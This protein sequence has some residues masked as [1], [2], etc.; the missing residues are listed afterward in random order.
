MVDKSLVRSGATT[1]EVYNHK[2]A[3]PSNLEE[4]VKWATDNFRRIQ[5]MGYDIEQVIA[6]V[7]ESLQNGAGGDCGCTDGRDGERGPRGVQGEQGPVGPAGP[8]ATADDLINDN[9][10]LTQKTYSSQKIESLFEESRQ[11]TALRWIDYCTSFVTDPVE[12]L[13]DPQV[14]QYEFVDRTLYRRITDTED[15]FYE[16]FNGVD[17]SRLVVS[18]AAGVLSN[19]V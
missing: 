4:A 17:V 19:G 5:E 14:L 11:Q 2:P 9:R 7:S 6:D 16:D 10:P 1:I 15:S 12:V 18:K 3:T 13:A 8:A